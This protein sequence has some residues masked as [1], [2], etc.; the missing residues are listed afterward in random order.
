[1]MKQI[2]QIISG[3][4]TFSLQ[5]G[6]EM[7]CAASY[8]GGFVMMG[9]YIH[10]KVDRWE[11]NKNIQAPI[12]L[13]DTILKAITSTLYPTFSRQDII[14]P[15][16]RSHLQKEKRSYSKICPCSNSNC[17]GLLVTGGS[18]RNDVKLS[19]TELYL[20]SRN[21]WTRGG[22]LPRHFI[23]ILRIVII[24][25]MRI[26]SSVISTIYM[27]LCSLVVAFVSCV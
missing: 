18:N 7:P 25:L 23:Q 22:A 11:K 19:S 5:N 9:G 12:S 27:R 14:T 10:G 3:G 1:M 20:P 26:K 17:K 8:Q 2:F 24:F 6:G 4:K 15:V 13:P 16:P 21:H